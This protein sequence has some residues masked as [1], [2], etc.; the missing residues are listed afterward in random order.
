MVS[1][2]EL[3]IGSAAERPGNDDRGGHDIAEVGGEF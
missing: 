1:I 2:I 3:G